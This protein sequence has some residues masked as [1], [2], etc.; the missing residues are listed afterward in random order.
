MSKK[1]NKNERSQIRN[2]QD[3]FN[4]L[5]RLNYYYPN[6][7]VVELLSLVDENFLTLSNKQ[8]SEKINNKLLEEIEKLKVEAKINHYKLKENVTKELLLENGFREG[9]WLK[10]IPNPKVLFVRNL[11]NSIEIHIE[12]NTE[13]MEFDDFNN[14][15]VLDDDFCQPYGPFYEDS[16]KVFENCAKVRNKYNKVMDELV[17][18]NILEKI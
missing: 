8:I 15:L 5:T 7:N 6:L 18:K 1:K 16:D 11:C 2:N 9:G 13:T 3:I 14:I 10:E 17:S 4:A 12:I